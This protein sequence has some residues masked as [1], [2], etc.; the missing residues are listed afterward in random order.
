MAGISSN[1]VAASSGSSVTGERFSGGDQPAASSSSSARRSRSGMA[2]VSCPATARTSN[3]ANDAGRSLMKAGRAA[4]EVIIRCCR[5]LKSRRSF[6]QAV[7]RPDER[8]AVHDATG[9]DLR[10]GGGHKLREVAV[11][12]GL[13]GLSRTSHF[14]PAT[15]DWNSSYRCVGHVPHVAS[16]CILGMS[17]IL[18]MKCRG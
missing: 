5:E 18:G 15:L 4:L 17:S 13:K 9:R 14:D 16:S 8:L 1:Q 11:L 7:V 6:V 2:R 12:L 3:A 10:L